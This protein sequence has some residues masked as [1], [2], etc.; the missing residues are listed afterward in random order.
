M[1]LKNL[2]IFNFKT[3]YYPNNNSRRMIPSA[4]TSAALGLYLVQLIFLLKISQSSGAR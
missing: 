1:F 2:A 4:Y 3:Y